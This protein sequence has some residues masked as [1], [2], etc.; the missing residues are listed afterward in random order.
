MVDIW[1][2]E[3]LYAQLAA[4]IRTKIDKGEY[5]PGERIPSELELVQEFNI[6]RGTARKALEVLRDEG[7][8]LTLPGRGS[9]VPPKPSK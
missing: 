7:K 6:S 9:F 4:L 1:S 5:K 8:I 3:P 2:R